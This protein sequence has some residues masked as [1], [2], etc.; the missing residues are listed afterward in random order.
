MYIPPSFEEHRVEALH[1]VIAS[2]PL[3]ILVTNGSGGL[4]ANHLVFELDPTHGEHGVLRTH[5]ARANP[6]WQNI[7]SGD[8]VLVVFRGA[9]AYISPN[10][11]PSKQETHKE[12]PTWNYV[13]VHAH[14]RAQIR[15]DVRH[16]RGLVGHLVKTHEASQPTPWKMGDSP[17]EFIDEALKAIVAIDVEVTRLVGK[18][19]LG[20]NRTLRDVHGAAQGLRAN[21]PSAVADA[22]LDHASRRPPSDGN[23]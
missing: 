3:G 19:K 2:Y 13:V 9:D 6:V 10:W 18:A 1:A 8:E 14:G 17:Q 20:Q 21:G 5:V 11:Y 12:V 23:R 16:L 7:S 4:D 15:D 22:M